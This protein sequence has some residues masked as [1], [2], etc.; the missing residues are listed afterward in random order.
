MRDLQLYLPIKKV[1]RDLQFL[2]GSFLLLTILAFFYGVR[3]SIYYSF[4]GIS[5]YWFHLSYHYL[6]SGWTWMLMLPLLVGL[7]KMI[8]SNG[9]FLLWVVLLA[10][11]VSVM[12]RVSSFFFD[13]TFRWGMGYTKSNP[14]DIWA[15]VSGPIYTG[16]FDSLL[17]Y[18]FIITAIFFF[19][20]KDNSI[21]PVITKVTEPEVKSIDKPHRIVA[22]KNGKLVFLPVDS[23]SAIKAEGN[24]VKVYK[25][26]NWVIIRETVKNMEQK[27]DASTF[28]RVNRSCIINV[29]FV[30]DLEPYFNGEYSITMIDGSVFRTGKSFRKNI[31]RLLSS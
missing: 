18:A 31:D 1:N 6:A 16:M 3:S 20:S 5:T 4:E 22:K 14:L 19:Y 21:V 8:R 27:L 29:N 2:V 9:G 23:I 25:D 17:A 13:A 10:A 28:F 15:D 7:R 26:S 12:H 24:Y 30:K 11:P